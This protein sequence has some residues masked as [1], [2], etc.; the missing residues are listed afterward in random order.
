MKHISMVQLRQSVAKIVKMLAKNNE[1]IIL[2]KGNKPVAVIIS[3]KDFNERFGEKAA[4]EERLE[5]FRKI[6]AMAIASKDS[7]PAE[8]IVRGL[9]NSR[10][11]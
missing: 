8:D 1:P 5:L 10:G 6:D 3:L 9:R 4:E 2:D 7:R 11:N